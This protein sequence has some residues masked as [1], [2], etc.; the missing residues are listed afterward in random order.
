M[1]AHRPPHIFLDETRYIITASTLNHVP[2]LADS[3]KKQIWRD[4]IMALLKE[5]RLALYAWVLLDNHY[6]LLLKVKRGH[7]LPRFIGRLH[8]STSFQINRLDNAR[9]RKV[10]YS[11]WDSCVRDEVDFWMKF[12]YI[13]NN[14]VKHGYVQ[15]WEGWEY[16]SYRYY[17]RTKGEEWLMDCWARYPVLNYLEGDDF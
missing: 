6:H 3:S 4:T 10:W 15:R 1:K 16:S 13:H 5:F 17:L 7:D 11:Y 12:N 2:Y 9:G 14:P 8:G